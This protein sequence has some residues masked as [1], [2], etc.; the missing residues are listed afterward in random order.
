MIEERLPFGP[1]TAQCLKKIED[2]PQL[3]KASLVRFCLLREHAYELSKIED[4]GTFVR[5]WIF[6]SAWANCPARQAAGL[7]LEKL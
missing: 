3:A 4:E 6:Q 1:H 7:S 5:L 2:S